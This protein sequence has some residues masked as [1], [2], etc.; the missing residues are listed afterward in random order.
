MQR[1][2]VQ[3]RNGPEGAPVVVVEIK[4]SM[5]RNE[6]E[7][8]TVEKVFKAE[9]QTTENRVGVI[10]PAYNTALTQTL[11]Q[12]NSWVVSLESSK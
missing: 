9:I 2:E 5:R 4:A 7:G 10:I 6:R 11:T 12:L 1:F 3:Y 8:V